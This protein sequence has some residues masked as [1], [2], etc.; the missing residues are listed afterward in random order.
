MDPQAGSTP[1]TSAGA[2]AAVAP[3]GYDEEFDAPQQPP[4]PRPG[5][6]IVVTVRW[7][8]RS[9]TT[10][11]TA[12]ILLFLLAVA[13][14][15]GS[16]IPQRGNNPLGVSQ[17]METHPALGKVYNTL[18]LFDV[19]ASPWFAAIYL[20]L[21]VSLAGCVLPRSG[22]HLKAMRAR[23][24]AAPRHIDRLPEAATWST[25]MG[26]GEA[27]SAAH[28]VL[29]S[30]RFRTDAAADS[31][32]AEKGHLRETGNL[33]FHLS[34]LVLLLGVALGGLWGY[35][36]TILV[37]EGDGFSNVLNQYDSFT[38]GRLTSAANLVPFSFVLDKFNA[39]YVEDGATRGSPATFN[40]LI[41]FRSSPSAAEKTYDVRVNHPLHVNGTKVYLV[42]HGYAPHFVVRDGEG[43]VAFDAAVPFLPQDGAFTSEGVVKVPD[44][45]PE[46][47]G[48]QGFF[49]PTGTIDPV[50]GP[51]SLFPAAD[52]PMVVLL[53]YKGDLG[54][55]SGI[56]QSVY[57]LETSR[58][59]KL[60]PASLRPGETMKL[61]D[62]LG[63]L[64]FTGYEQWATFQVTSD[65]GKY[66]ALV[67][68]IA[69]IG[70][71]L[72]SLR[73]RR[74]R[75]WVRAVAGEGRTVV[76][77]GGLTRSDAESFTEEFAGLTE[78]MR[79][80]VPPI[81]T[82]VPADTADEAPG[83]LPSLQSSEPDQ[84]EPADGGTAEP[85]DGT[86]EE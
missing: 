28:A 61:P 15:P 77:L 63:T 20:L 29:R 69:M 80:A 86:T 35:K 39:T 52:N 53:A 66:I 50:R 73:I 60:G 43:H 27:L 76:T 22:K 64:E 68:A 5:S 45:L 24:P 70:G 8:W 78:R 84:A 58:L 79:A 75:L 38:P 1:D 49:L 14:I 46:Q 71:L 11:R 3:D 47:L 36:G 25:A 56:P 41:R 42:G 51:M 74:R 44:A 23:P 4:R 37:K 40:A 26:P 32:S 17:Y 34:L 2:V 31:V 19:F 12:L 33:V 85:A 30:R 9:L 65:P 13:A 48:F 62:G 82:E 6:S 57:S 72:L 83:E 55:G 67:S 59:T 16:I 54:L 10:M 21:F 18:G 81:P 7:C